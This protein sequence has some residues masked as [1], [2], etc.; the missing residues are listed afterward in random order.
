MKT[1]RDCCKWQQI[2]GAIITTRLAWAAAKLQLRA[3]ALHVFTGMVC[4]FLAIEKKDRKVPLRTVVVKYRI[5]NVT[6][7]NNIWKF[8][9]CTHMGGCKWREQWGEQWGWG[10]GET[11][12]LQIGFFLFRPCALLSGN[13]LGQPSPCFLSLNR[14]EK[15]SIFLL[16]HQVNIV[17]RP[18]N[19]LKNCLW[20]S[21]LNPPNN[22]A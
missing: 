10:R 11:G 16:Q 15:P 14:H 1:F 3:Q 5:V 4:L 22:S 21:G 12:Q 2:L 17:T 7:C 8:Q 19:L 6:A 20:S 18:S 9:T 13:V